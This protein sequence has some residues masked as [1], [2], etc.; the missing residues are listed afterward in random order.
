VVPAEHRIDGFGQFSIVGFVNATGIDPDKAARVDLLLSTDLL[1]SSHF[2]TRNNFRI[3]DLSLDCGLL[4]FQL[5]VLLAQALVVVV[6]LVPRSPEG[7]MG[8]DSS[9]FGLD[10]LNTVP[11]LE[12][13]LVLTPTVRQYC[14]R[15]YRLVDKLLHPHGLDVEE[16]HCR[17][18]GK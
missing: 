2:N 6:I 12:R 5:M 7:N 4:F 18:E 3:P 16:P 11:L 14:V 15:G 8:R 9:H 13:Y 1:I 10:L 17:T